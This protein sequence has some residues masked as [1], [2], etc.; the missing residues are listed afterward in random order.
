MQI[1]FIIQIPF[2]PILRNKKMGHLI[3]FRGEK[4]VNLYLKKK[5]IIAINFKIWT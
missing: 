2:I 3:D 5:I 4:K 1:L